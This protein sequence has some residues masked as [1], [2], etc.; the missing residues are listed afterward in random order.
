MFILTYY[1]TFSGH[2]IAVYR[3]YGLLND[4]PIKKLV[5]D[6]KITFFR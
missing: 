6:S 4:T 2:C 3:R 5:F 1:D